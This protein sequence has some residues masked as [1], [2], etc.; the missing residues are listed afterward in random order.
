MISSPCKTC[1]RKNHPKEDC[2]KDCE[3]LQAMQSIQQSAIEGLIAPGI[4]YSEENRFTINH[5]TAKMSS[6]F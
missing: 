3:L 1:H 5:S 6:T 2:Y 4:D